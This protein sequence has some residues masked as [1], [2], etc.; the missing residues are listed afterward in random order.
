[1]IMMDVPGVAEVKG[2]RA[3]MFVLFYQIFLASAFLIGGRIGKVMSQA[4]C[5]L[6]FK[7]DPAYFNNISSAQ[8]YPYYYFWRNLILSG[9]KL[10]PK[11][12][13]RY[14]PSVPIVYLYADHKPFQFHGA[15][16]LRLFDKTNEANKNN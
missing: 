12:L 5:K 7:H 9:L 14:K 2:L 4:V 16:W 11:Y 3:I 1:M 8:N 13:R 6:V 15:R 10:K